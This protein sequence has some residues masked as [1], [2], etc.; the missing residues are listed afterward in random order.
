MKKSIKVILLVMGV[1]FI[2]TFLITIVHDYYLMK[3]RIFAFPL[4]IQFTIMLSALLFFIPGIICLIV[5]YV[6]RRKEAN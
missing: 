5:A 1:L 4:G 2:L 6:L 3:T